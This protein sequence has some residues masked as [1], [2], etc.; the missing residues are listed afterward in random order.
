MS[1][2]VVQVRAD[3][4]ADCPTPC[5]RQLDAAFHRDPCAAC[6][7]G[8][9]GQWGDCS[10]AQSVPSL[11]APG[12]VAAPTGLRGLGDLV[13]VVAEPIAR[14]IGLDPARC[15]CGARR[16]AMNRAFPFG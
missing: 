11:P 9:W 13:A 14:V 10:A 12:G 6:P 4:C 2:G 7:I 3:L 16:E 5:E 15:G 8:R 1:P